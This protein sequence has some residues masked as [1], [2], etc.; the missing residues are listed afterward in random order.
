MSAL[1]Q[2]L[3]VRAKFVFSLCVAGAALPWVVGWVPAGAAT[4]VWLLDLGAHW[5]WAYLLVGSA[6]ALW[7][8]VRR[9]YAWA[10]PGALLLGA[11]WWVASPGALALAASPARTLTVVSANLNAGNDD[12]SALQRWARGLDAD[13]L[14][15][16]EV[17]PRSAARLA[18]WGDYPH[19]LLAPEDGPF[20]LAVLSRHRL[21][22]VALREPPG[23]TPHARLQVH[24]D[25]GRAPA[26]VPLALAV[27]HPMPP[28]SAHYHRQRDALLATEAVW[29]AGA[30]LPAL[31]AGDFNASPWS[32]AMRQ[33]G[34]AGMRRATGLTPTWPA[35]LPAIPIDQILVSGHWRVVESGVGP[36]VGSDHRPVFVRLALDAPGADRIRAGSPDG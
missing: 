28:L 30:G 25:A 26:P 21:G 13:L 35:A 5:Q 29:A 20:G 27:L 24:W 14:L 9:A 10:L 17:N 22:Q 1:S 19:Q 15:L 18:G 3:L 32:S 11:G 12:P 34:A 7:L 6:C 31:M 33:P 4:F 36:Q 23:Q 16:Q 8:L 2:A